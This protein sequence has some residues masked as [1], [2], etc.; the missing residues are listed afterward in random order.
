MVRCM[1][2]ATLVVALSWIVTGSAVA[3]E[4]EI[5]AK[6]PDFK[7]VGIDGKEY[8]ADSFKGSKATVIV[9]TCNHCPVAV[10]YEDRFIDFQKKYADQGV[11]FIAINVNA[12][13]DLADMRQRAEEKGINYVYAY[14]ESGDSARAYGARVTP[15]LFV[16]DATGAVAYRGSFDDKQADPTTAYVEDA[17]QALLAGQKPETQ[18]TRAFGC[19]IK[20]RRK[21][22]SQN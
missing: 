12:S 10:A 6:G 17:V 7:A 16:L 13:E 8:S 21:S 5:G 11:K 14:D 22:A 1:F 2:L 3:D 9:F 15:H 20:P 19:G 18:S 4:V